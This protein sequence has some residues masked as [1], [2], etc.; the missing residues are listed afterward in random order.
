MKKQ[1][2]LFLIFLLL[3]SGCANKTETASQ[4]LIRNVS[5]QTIQA[6]EYANSIT[7]SGTVIP[8][9]TV[10]L[11]FKIPGIVSNLSVKEGDEV[12]AGQT[13]AKLD[14]NDYR[15]NVQA[16]QAQVAGSRSSESA[17]LA[18][19]QG[20]QAQLD[21]TDV[22]IET[23]IPTKIN[24][25][26]AQLDLIQ[27]NYDRIK[28]MTDQGIAPQSSLDEISTQ[29][30]VAKNTYQ[31]ALDAK[32]VAETSRQAIAAQLEAAKAQYE[33]Y[34]SQTDAASAALSLAN[35]NISDT[36][37]QSPIQ[38]VVLQ[39]IVESGEV[40]SA[41]YPIVAIGAVDQVWVEIGVTDESINSLQKGQKAKVYVY[42]IDQVIEG[43]IDEVGAVADATTRTFS[44]KIL[45][46]NTNQLL[47]PGMI[48]KVDIILNGGEK[49]LI[50][51]SSV[52]HLAS[53]S[54]VFLYSS[55]TNTVTKR[56]IETGEII[57][58]KIEVLSGLEF[59]ET[60][61]TDGQYVLHDG[62]PVSLKEE[63]TEEMEQ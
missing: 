27:T 57:Q 11:S 14:Q 22:Q 36:T 51:V 30:E 16:A 34:G 41:G 43:V 45:V 63:Q 15:I 10:K 48:C 33:A 61:V 40:V 37:I 7:L 24:Q 32:T 19:I 17:A 47:K 21:A 5:V 3:L 1:S 56:I 42:G 2:S 59:G 25:A 49:I 38:G 28:T 46:N 6:S 53:G 26:K 31:Q 44:V 8:T 39:K 12:V 62:D 60:L 4:P 18:Q 50:P 20:A 55:D 58:D 9:Q 54:A 13:I 23:E 29:L 35:S 52:I